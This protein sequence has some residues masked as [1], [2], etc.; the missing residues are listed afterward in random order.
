MNK[1]NDILMIK[2][3]DVWSIGPE[4]LVFDAIKLMTDKKVGA[5]MV[6]EDTKLVGVISET[7]YTRKVILLGRA[8]QNTRVKEIMTSPVVYVQP[9]QDIEECMIIMTKK[10]TRHLPVMDDGKLIGLVPLVTS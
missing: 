10:H 9:E 1:V 6:I 3:H 7:D 2:G 5:L 4:A 8:S